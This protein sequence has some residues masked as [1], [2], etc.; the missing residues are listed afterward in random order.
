VFSASYRESQ[1]LL[2]HAIRTEYE[3][4]RSFL[5]PVFGYYRSLRRVDET[6]ESLA[7]REIKPSRVGPISHMW[8]VTLVQMT[9][10]RERVRR[11]RIRCK[12]PDKDANN[13]K[14]LPRGDPKGGESHITE[15]S[16]LLDAAGISEC[17]IRVIF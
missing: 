7:R 15:G 17:A 14:R 8:R 9:N 6:F 10:L 2:L 12:L 13:S 16:L 4:S 11:I 5:F 1:L 3:L